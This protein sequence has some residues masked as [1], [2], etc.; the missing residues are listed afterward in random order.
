MYFR[1]YSYRKDGK[2]VSKEISDLEEKRIN[3]YYDNRIQRGTM[4]EDNGLKRSDMD[5][6]IISFDTWELGRD[7]EFEDRNQLFLEDT[8]YG[9]M[10]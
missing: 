10:R 2:T 7:I 6:K 3:S 9:G 5:Y 1:T 4:Q 8:Y